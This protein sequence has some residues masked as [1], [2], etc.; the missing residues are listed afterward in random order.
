LPDSSQKKPIK[1]PLNDGGIET[2]EYPK[3]RVGSKGAGSQPQGGGIAATEAY[4]S[5]HMP[6]LLNLVGTDEGIYVL[7]LHSFIEGFVYRRFPRLNRRNPKFNEVIADFGLALRGDGL[8][9]QA[10]SPVLNKIEKE[11]ALTNDVRHEFKTL[12]QE[13]ARAATFNFK[14]FCSLVDV[15][16]PALQKLEDSLKQWEQH[17]TPAEARE[18]LAR[19]K[20]DLD[21]TQRESRMLSHDAERF[22]EIRED[23]ERLSGEH[24]ELAR[25]LD[26]TSTKAGKHKARLD[27]LRRDLYQKEQE[28]RQLQ[29]ELDQ[30]QPAVEAVRYLERLTAYT[31]TRADYER[32]ILRLTPEQESAVRVVG[33][34]KNALIKG[35]AGTGKS[36]VLLHVFHRELA[37]RNEAPTL[38][39]RPPMV[40][41]T[42]ANTLVKYSEYLAGL[43][44]DEV[45]PGTIL[46]VDAFILRSLRKLRPTASIDYKLSARMAKELNAT[47]FLSDTELEA[48]IEDFI[49]GNLVTE[50]EYIDQRLRR[51]GLRQPLSATQRE[52]VWTV[53]D[54][55]IEVMDNDG[56]YTRNYARARLLELF[57]QQPSEV[58]QLVM[59]RIFVDETQD[60]FAADL[61]V[62]GRLSNRGLVMAGDE[63]QSIY[64]VGSPFE[65]AGVS[66]VGRTRVLKTNFRNTRSIFEIAEEYRRSFGSARDAEYSNLRAFRE[67][68]EPELILRGHKG[69]LLQVLRDRVDLFCRRL[70]YDPENVAILAP[71]KTELEDAELILNQAGYQTWNLRSGEAEFS[72]PGYVRLSTL[73]SSKG[74]DFPVVVLYVPQFPVYE[75]LDEATQEARD[76]NLI[77]VGLTRAMD[78]L[79]VITWEHTHQKP[80]LDLISVFG[81]RT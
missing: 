8:S 65:R 69:E 31:R 67:G 45:K 28:R 14:R 24:R 21:K 64:T 15:A 17:K 36:I 30:L 5:E 62:L 40:Y 55:M 6:R 35:S 2:G 11:H 71:T 61:A 44:E 68:P 79:S 3:I 39:E 60:L 73:H 66:V 63:E 10:F 75:D 37:H 50:E 12:T 26:D 58:D 9:S 34:S 56:V 29:E 13:E 76:R 43:L 27:E 74:I 23:Y 38:Q 57:D 70:G 25:Q 22:E 16:H 54:R 52:R 53:R 18:Q 72:E 33:D 47:S 59:D 7:A 20:I 41:L 78:N 80:L 42:Y 81:R 48:E 4:V 46:T 49:F 32:S 77:Y 1:S 19:L 51:R